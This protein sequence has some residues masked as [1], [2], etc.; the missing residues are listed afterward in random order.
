MLGVGG[1]T[2]VQP[3]HDDK[4]IL[5]LFGQ[6]FAKLG[7]NENPPLRI[8]RNL[9]FAEKLHAGTPFIE[10]TNLLHFTPLSPTAKSIIRLSIECQVYF[11]Q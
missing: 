8:Y 2:P 5:S 10:S 11:C 6:L 3:A 7:R 1:Q 9:V 4:G